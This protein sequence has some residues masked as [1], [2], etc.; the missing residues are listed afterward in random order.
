MTLLTLVD[1]EDVDDADGIE[2]TFSRY[3][4]WGN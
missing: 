4:A 3:T 2:D 1:A